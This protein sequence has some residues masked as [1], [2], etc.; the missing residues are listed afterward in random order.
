LVCEKI[1]AKAFFCDVFHGLLAL[2]GT[3]TAP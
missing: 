1:L 3:L 2:G